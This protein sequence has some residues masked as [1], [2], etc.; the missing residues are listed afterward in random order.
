MQQRI[1]TYLVLFLVFIFACDTK[2]DFEGEFQNYFIRY[3]GEDGDQEA[4]DFYRHA[5]GSIVILGT[6]EQTVGVKKILL[7]KTDPNG[8]LQWQIKAEGE[9]GTLT[10]LPQDIEPAPDGGYWVL[11]N[12]LMGVDPVTNENIYDFKVLHVTPNGEIDFTF[13]YGNNAGKWKT[14]F[15]RSITPLSHGGFAIV[16]N[17][18]DENISQDPD[19]YATPDIEDL[20]AIGFDASYAILWTLI[21]DGSEAQGDETGTPG[22][23]IGMALKLFEVTPSE[24]HLFAFSD[25]VQQVVGTSTNFNAFHLDAFGAV[26]GEAGMAG[27]GTNNYEVLNAVCAVPA[28]RGG[29]YYEFGTSKTSLS[30]PAGTLYFCRKRSGLNSDYQIEG[31]IIGISGTN[32]AVDATP[33]LIDDTFLLLANDITSSGSSILLSKVTEDGQALWSVHLGTTLRRNEGKRIAEFADG[34][35]LVLATIELATQKK[36][37]LMKVNQRGEFL[38]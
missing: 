7:L 26:Y 13:I 8:L 37:A 21:N 35:I 10:E 6:T 15:A 9:E 30:D 16:G 25:H 36:I 20:F 33:S 32:V 17:S 4:V 28:A 3:Y 11:T 22:E 5:D 38:N 1:S 34:R 2:S 24:Y 29:G 14:Q 19:G 12:M 18:T 23:Q 31:P 27:V